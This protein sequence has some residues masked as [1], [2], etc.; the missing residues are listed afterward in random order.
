LR[1]RAPMFYWTLIGFGGNSDIPGAIYR[2]FFLR[3]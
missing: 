2:G 1:M 3:S